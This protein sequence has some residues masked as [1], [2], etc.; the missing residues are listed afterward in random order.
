M[1]VAI[2]AIDS[3]TVERTTK[4]LIHK[5]TLE[6]ERSRLLA[7]I[8]A[9]KAEIDAAYQCRLDVIEENLTYFKK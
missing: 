6:T 8:T 5:D 9:K 3:N 1:A 4:T 7:E 2:Q